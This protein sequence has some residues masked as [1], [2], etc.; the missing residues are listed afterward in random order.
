M[1]ENS[2]L[3]N[4]LLLLSSLWTSGSG[5][6]LATTSEV[7][8]IA[9]Q[10]PLWNYDWSRVVTQNQWLFLSTPRPWTWLKFEC[11]DGCCNA[12]CDDRYPETFEDCIA[13]TD[14]TCQLT[15]FAKVSIHAE[16][17]LC[18]IRNPAY[19]DYDYDGTYY[20]WQ[21]EWN[22]SW[23]PLGS[24]PYWLQWDNLHNDCANGSVYLRSAYDYNGICKT[25]MTWGERRQNVD[26]NSIGIYYDG[27]MSNAYGATRAMFMIACRNIQLDWATIDPYFIFKVSSLGLKG[28]IKSID[29]PSTTPPP[30]S[31][32]SS[33]FQ[34]LL[35]DPSITPAVAAMSDGAL[36][37]IRITSILLTFILIV[38]H[39]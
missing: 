23:I 28:I 19:G 5:Q 18:L 38:A 8:N 34:G 14:Q 39:A 21:L 35:S 27:Q 22:I 13:N 2:L 26:S 37:T 3:L 11:P 25:E 20:G 36:H 7:S 24:N 29:R 16:D 31:T 33:S 9:D 12:I 4:L 17:F 6:N 15:A 32:T 10:Y 1:V 30:P